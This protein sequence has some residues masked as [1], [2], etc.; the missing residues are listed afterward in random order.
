MKLNQALFG[1]HA[2]FGIILGW[3]LATGGGRS[4]APARIAAAAPAATDS[5][6][7][8]RSMSA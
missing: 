1:L 5:A 3:V 4:A 2:C 7:R 8:R 6:R